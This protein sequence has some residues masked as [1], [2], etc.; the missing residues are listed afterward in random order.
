MNQ[1]KKFSIA[2][3]FA[4]LISTSMAGTIDDDYAS[5]DT[6]TAQHMQNIKQ[7][8]N[9]NDSRITDNAGAISSSGLISYSAIDSFSCDSG[10]TDFIEDEYSKVAD[11]GQ[12]TKTADGSIMDLTFNGTLYIRT[13]EGTGARFELR[14]ND[15]PTTIGRARAAIKSPEVAF[16]VS[17]VGLFEN[18]SVGNHT[19]SMWVSGAHGGGTLA[20]VDAGCWSTDVVL[21]KEFNILVPR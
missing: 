18:L 13:M 19:V 16:Q 17:I 15:L 7:A 10:N 4:G 8:V 5:G 6:L 12:F 20:L 11:L 14:V 1:L 21:V 2:I 3:S 9:D